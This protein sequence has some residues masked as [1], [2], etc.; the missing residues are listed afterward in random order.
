MG[1]YRDRI[2]PRVINTVCG[3]K[4]SE[5]YR[6]RVCAG[7]H[8]DVIEIGFGSGTNVPFYPSHVRSVA[9]IE[10]A[11]VAWKLAAVLQGWAGP[12]LL[13]SYEA[14]RRPVAERTIAAAGAQDAF[15]APATTRSHCIAGPG[16][17]L[18]SC[19]W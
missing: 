8:G 5:P 11:D 1:I 18:F 9:A 14:E 12:G 3:M 15:L 16:S 6:E 4:T 17:T 2:L 13:D 19:T 7:L 10:P